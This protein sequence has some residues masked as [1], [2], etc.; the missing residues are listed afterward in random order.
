MFGPAAATK[1][2]KLIRLFGSDRDG[3]VVAA[4]G[5]LRRT[6]ASNGS[7][8]HELAKLVTASP[9][10]AP[11]QDWLTVARWCHARGHRLNDRERG[12]LR[13]MAE[14]VCN[15]SEKQLAWLSAIHVRLRRGE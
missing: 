13:S 10:P 15:P 5:A 3:E 2:G 6:L 9:A 1:L 14:R 11:A 12:F 7:D 8:L 4:A